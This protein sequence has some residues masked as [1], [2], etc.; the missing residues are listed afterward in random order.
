MFSLLF[1]GDC[2]QR[3]STCSQDTETLHL[4]HT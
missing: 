4:S 3:V 2:Q 1:V